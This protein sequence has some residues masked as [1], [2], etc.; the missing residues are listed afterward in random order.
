[1]HFFARLAALP[2]PSTNKL[3]ILEIL[4][5]KQIFNSFKMSKRRQEYRQ[6]G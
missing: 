5:G 1:M 2:R 6:A 3:E 4:A